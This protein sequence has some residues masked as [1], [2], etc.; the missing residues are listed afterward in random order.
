[1]KNY[2]HEV[3]ER[4]AK[5]GNTIPAVRSAF[6]KGYSFSHL[7]FEEQL[8]VWEFIWKTTDN[9]RVKTQPFFYCERYAMKEQHASAAWHALKH[10]QN[11]VSDWPFC[12]GLSNIY[13]RHLE[14]F[15]DEVFAQL[16]KWNKDK[17]LWKRRQSIVSLL[18]YA[19]TK[20]K[21]L[22]FSQ[23]LPLIENLLHD[24][25]YYVQKGV[26]WS[27]RELYNVY[28]GKTFTWMKQNIRSI[29]AIAFSAATE[30]VTVKEK[31]I[32]KALRKL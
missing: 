2:L 22:S 14:F 15:P 4:I 24:K 21:Y 8:L 7:P 12:D 13:T 9:W 17:D 10:W 23:I 32:L 1:M 28:P 26:G 25:E 19:R 16:K 20:K 27:L 6:K 5:S 29:S 3:S 30:K 31:S 18:Y 11:H